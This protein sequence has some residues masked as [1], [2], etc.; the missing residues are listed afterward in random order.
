M[1]IEVIFKKSLEFNSYSCDN[2]VLTSKV[3]LI[4]YFLEC[5]CF[6]SSLLFIFLGVLQKKE[7]NSQKEKK[8]KSLGMCSNKC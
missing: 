4:N 8:G 3:F 6:F 2:N 1:S 5:L 7:N